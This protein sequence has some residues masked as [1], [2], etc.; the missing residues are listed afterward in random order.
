MTLLNGAGP[1]FSERLRKGGATLALRLRGYNGEHDDADVEA[2]LFSL[3]STADPRWDGTDIRVPNANDL[4]S[5][6]PL[7]GRLVDTQA[8]V[9]DD[10]LVMSFAGIV[11]IGG[12][13]VRFVD[14][15]VVA[16]LGAKGN[17]TTVVEGHLTGRLPAD[18]SSM[19]FSRE[20]KP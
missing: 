18:G 14:G 5:A 8:F 4:A 10:A 7:I 15:R 3:V 20:E 1:T 13:L 12:I 6:E 17:A 19:A 9:R 16:K 2:T 11:P